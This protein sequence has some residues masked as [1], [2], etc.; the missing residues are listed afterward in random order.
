MAFNGFRLVLGN[1]A[2]RSR[3]TASTSASAGGD[4][5][6]LTPATIQPRPRGPRGGRMWGVCA[7]CIGMRYVE[8][9]PPDVALAE[10]AKRQWGVVSLAQLQALGLDRAAVARR[11]AAGRL[12]RL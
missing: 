12:H 9:T 10:V 6:L 4:A 7:L 2:A 1:A 11:V 8:H 3:P 5:L